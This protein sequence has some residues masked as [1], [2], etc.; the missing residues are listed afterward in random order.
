MRNGWRLKRSSVFWTTKRFFV[1]GAVYI[2]CPRASTP[3]VTPL[4]LVPWCAGLSSGTLETPR[5]GLQF[6]LFS[7][8]CL[9]CYVR[10]LTEPSVYLLTIIFLGSVSLS[11]GRS[12]TIIGRMFGLWG[13]S[14]DFWLIFRHFC[15][16]VI[17]TD[18]VGARVEVEL[19]SENRPWNTPMPFT[20]VFLD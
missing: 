20:F 1:G 14:I 17:G 4:R 6:N 3:L 8:S 10:S 11:N 15:A 18:S 13:L 19:N 9:A 16:F 5:L 2:P 7:H 12:Q